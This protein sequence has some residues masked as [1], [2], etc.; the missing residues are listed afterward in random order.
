MSAAHPLGRLATPPLFDVSSLP[1]H[2]IPPSLLFLLFL[3]AT[4]DT[5]HT[6][7]L[8]TGHSPLPPVPCRSLPNTPKAG[9]TLTHFLYYNLTFTF[10]ERLT[11]LCCFLFSQHILH[12][13][14]NGGSSWMN[15]CGSSSTMFLHWG[16]RAAVS[17][18]LALN[19]CGAPPHPATECVVTALFTVALVPPLPPS[20]VRLHCP[21][22]PGPPAP[23]QPYNQCAGEA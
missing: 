9:I 4:T 20:S 6:T 5:T 15:L 16:L 22:R 8:I 17:S 10:R 19:L 3:A 14:Q 12:Q 13:L 1:S 21:L 23:L 7:L 11:C 2:R 18:S